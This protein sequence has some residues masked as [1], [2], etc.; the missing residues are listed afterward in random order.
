M[1]LLR[2][3]ADSEVLTSSP[4]SGLVG[5]G[6]Y[7]MRASAELAASASVLSAVNTNR[8][9]RGSYATF[10]TKEK[11]QSNKSGLWSTEACLDYTLRLILTGLRNIRFAVETAGST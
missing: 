10:P 4:L 9:A 1:S 2:S 7:G 6:M 5:Y 11:Q 3:T 8:D